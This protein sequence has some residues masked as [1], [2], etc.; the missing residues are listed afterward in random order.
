MFRVFWHILLFIF[1]AY[2]MNVELQKNIN[3]LYLQTYTKT[4]Y[5]I[6][7]YATYGV[8]TYRYFLISLHTKKF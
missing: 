2:A 7:I 5:Q 1:R 3:F 8:H 6:A 4:I